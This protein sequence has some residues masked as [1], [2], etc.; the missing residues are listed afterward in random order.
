MLPIG[1][2]IIQNSIQ[3]EVD[4][5]FRIVLGAME[6]WIQITLFLLNLRAGIVI[7]IRT[8]PMGQLMILST[9]LAHTVHNITRERASIMGNLLC[10]IT[11]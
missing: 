8:T 6:G 9:P 10:R 4:R 3:M 11:I 2:M 1:A 7:L 5:E